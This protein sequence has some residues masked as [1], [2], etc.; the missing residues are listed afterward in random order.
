[1][2]AQDRT[3]ARA[4]EKPV[5]D[6]FTVE[7]SPEQHTTLSAARQAAGLLQ[8]RLRRSLQIFCNGELIDLKRY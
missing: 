4:A 3:T 7:G 5:K 2:D 1:M 8:Q 6:V